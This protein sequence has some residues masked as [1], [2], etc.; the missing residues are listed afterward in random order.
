MMRIF[1]LLFLVSCG[2]YSNDGNRCFTQEE[3]VNYCMVN[4]LKEGFT[5]E[6][7][8]RINCGAKYPVEN[9]CYYLD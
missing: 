4:E 8:A 2:E 3:A 5:T 1:F 7:Q 6:E 9:Y